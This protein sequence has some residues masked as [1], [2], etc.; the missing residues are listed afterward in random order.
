MWSGVPSPGGIGGPAH[1]P[2]TALQPVSCRNILHTRDS[3]LPNPALGAK[4][5]NT[6]RERRQPRQVSLEPQSAAVGGAQVAQ[7]LTYRP[8]RSQLAS[9]L[10]LPWLVSLAPPI[11]HPSA[12]SPEY[13]SL[14]AQSC[15]DPE[16]CH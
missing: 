7:A 5:G 16:F 15:Q 3:R 11:P 8:P 14:R 4:A 12:G 10:A 6:M 1:V 2:S 9:S 13:L